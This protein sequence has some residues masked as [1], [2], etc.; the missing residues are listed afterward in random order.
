MTEMAGREFAYA[1]D[2]S[3]RLPARVFGIRPDT[4]LIIVTEEQL[5]ARFG[6]WQVHTSLANIKSMGITGPYRYL[7][8]VGPARLGITDRGLTFATN[9]RRGVQ[10]DFHESISGIERW[11]RLRHPN[12][13]LTA[14]D[15]PGLID[16]CKR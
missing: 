14:A 4:C 12:L 16:A 7:K 11:G 9:A 15:C 10:F 8:T 3:F 1:F 5:L 2:P 6:P 13:T